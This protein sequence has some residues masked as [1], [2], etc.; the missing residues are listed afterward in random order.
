MSRR[1]GFLLAN[2]PQGTGVRVWE[3][4]NDSSLNSGDGAV[5]VLPGGRLGYK[6][7]DEYLRNYIYK[8]ATAENLDGV[9]VWGSTLAGAATWQEAEDF[10]KELGNVMPVVSMGI[11]V[12]GVPSVDFDAYSGTYRMVEHMIRRHGARRIAFLRGPENHESAQERFQA[13]ADALR[14]NG[15]Q[16]D[17]KLVSSPMPWGEGE[18]AIREIVEKNGMVPKRDFNAMV[19]PSDLMNHMATRYLEERGYLIPDDIATAGFN[20]TSDVY[21]NS[22]ESTTV[23]MPYK[24]MVESSFSLIRDMEG[25]KDGFFSDLSLPS[26]PVYRRSCGCTDPFGSEESARKT[27]K[28]WEDYEK[29][30]MRRLSDKEAAKV[31]VSIL[32]DLFE[33]ERTVSSESRRHYGEMIW[34]YLKHGGT[35]KLFFSIVKWTRIL[36]GTREPSMDEMEILHDIVM[37]Q[38]AR[39]SAAKSFVDSEKNKAFIR[40]S[41]DLL[42]SLSFK[43][44]GEAFSR[45]LPSIGLEKAFVFLS[46]GDGNSRLATGFTK[47]K[48]WGEGENFPD[49]RIY[50]DYLESE[51]ERGIF[52]VLPLFY[53]SSVVG[54]L[55]VEN[56]SCPPQ[57]VEN[58]RNSTSA[59]LQAISLYNIAS[60]KSRK[61][62]EAEK[63]SSQFYATLAEDLKEPLDAIKAMAGCGD[64][65][66]DILLALSTKAEHILQL[67]LS[68]KGELSMEPKVVPGSVLRKEIEDRGIVVSSPDVIP[69]VFI[70]K[71]KVGEVLDYLA[72]RARSAGDT[73]SIEICME[74]RNLVLRTKGNVFDVSALSVKDPSML[75]CE[76]IMVMHGGTFRFGKECL[77]IVFPFPSISGS[78]S[79]GGG[80][81]G[82]LFISSKA[83]AIPQGLGIKYQWMGYED[84]VQRIAEIPSY[85]A[86]AW[87][88]EE[89][90]KAANV[91]LTVLQNH[92]ETRTMPFISY[93]A[94]EGGT[95][96]K[97][98]VDEAILHSVDS[99]IYSF[100]PF[101]KTLDKLRDFGSVVEVDSPKNVPDDA[102]VALFVIEKADAAIVESVKKRRVFS[103]TPFLVVMDK[104]T[105][106]DAESLSPFPEVLMVNT[107]ITESEDFIAR[108]LSLIGGDELLPPLTSVLVKRAIAYLN[109][110]ATRSVSRWQI[111]ASVNISEDYLTRIFRKEV[112]ISPWDY[113]NRFRIQ[114]A[115]RLLLET[116][117]SISEIAGM[118][119][120]QDQAYFCRV[121]RKVKGFPPG[122]IRSRSQA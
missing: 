89:E 47:G 43:D 72:A 108:V 66:G 6:K 93:G 54:Y 58:I 79:S 113:L 102:K 97:S 96:L 114:I 56:K 60:I 51:F 111:A 53:D 4:I 3:C 21:L 120:F 29:W 40:L 22:V 16:F 34:R 32:H 85:S 63:K 45:N 112:G 116:G 101:P 49:T 81:K 31:L 57:M 61:A 14:D 11:R 100:G 36:L 99:S 74:D 33:E 48:I 5:F 2:L 94:K 55:V 91:A 26:V 86:I 92:R 115:S 46:D 50:P 109:E 9:V 118:T 41:S 106:E 104:F 119:G 35:M 122:S 19:C 76:R 44:I 64:L 28:T 25:D 110:Y 38:S 105:R 37:E 103:K 80:E 8:F 83:S 98:T 90:S 107:S 62:E 117:A 84:V 77:D 69:S 10:V 82:I 95:N 70:D 75:L 18:A 87:N 7:A 24:E 78:P 88:M 15:I 39:V 17:P 12:D 1:T 13:Y 20:D 27:I 23:R 73:L 42:K 52:I 67:S 59:T 71:G 121:F 68:D 65:D 30:I